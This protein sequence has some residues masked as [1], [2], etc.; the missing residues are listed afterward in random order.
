MDTAAVAAPPAPVESAAPA[1]SEPVVDT[2]NFGRDVVIKEYEDP[3][4]PVE[5]P[6]EE[7][8]VE[9]PKGAA[10]PADEPAPEKEVRLKDYRKGDGN[11]DVDKIESTVQ[12]A[13][14]LE[15]QWNNMNALIARRPEIELA[16]LKALKE[17]G[18]QLTADAEAKLAAA[19][20]PEA[21]KPADLSG[22]W[23]ELWKAN[24]AKFR[25]IE[26]EYGV[27]S[28]Q[29]NYF[30]MEN[31]QGPYFEAKMEAKQADQKAKEAA[32]NQK[33]ETAR[34]SQ[35]A[36]V[37]VREQVKE[38]A[39]KY[40]TIFVLDEKMPYGGDFKDKAVGDEVAKLRANIGGVLS[41]LE[42][43]E[44]ALFRLKRL[45]PEGAAPKAP[46]PALPVTRQV[47]VRKTAPVE[48]TGWQRQVIVKNG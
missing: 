42:L 17:D 28:A 45:K 35:A 14:V 25:E 27:G 12:K 44:I 34:L 23:N 21:P 29:A 13:Q 32:E 4:K 11:F 16:M 46:A 22:K 7:E 8:A 3:V 41:I 6:V 26:T 31:L 20:K 48:S 47:P 43:T 37:K 40:K 9:A 15:G 38:A 33:R 24:G 18:V 19:P 36:A 39:D 5:A 2:E 10:T 30:W 1:P